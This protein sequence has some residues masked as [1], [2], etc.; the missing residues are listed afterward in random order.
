[1]TRFMSGHPEAIQDL[2]KIVDN[3]RLFENQVGAAN[4]HLMLGTCLI[5]LGEL[6]RAS[7]H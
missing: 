4:T 2:E 6:E 3:M 5:Q 1:M 7:K